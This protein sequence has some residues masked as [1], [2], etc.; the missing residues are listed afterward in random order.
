MTQQEE[1]SVKLLGENKQKKK[2]PP[3][4]LKALEERW[5]VH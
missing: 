1:K 3:V 5:K 2:T 4:W